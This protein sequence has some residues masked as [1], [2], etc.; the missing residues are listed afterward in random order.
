MPMDAQAQAHANSQ[1]AN[2]MLALMEAVGEG[3]P[4]DSWM[5]AQNL[6]LVGRMF[7]DHTVLRAA[8]ADLTRYHDYM[9]ALGR[10]ARWRG[11]IYP[12]L[13][14]QLQGRP[15]ILRL[16]PTSRSQLRP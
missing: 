3:R 16:A 8:F 4:V 2:E 7:D 9:T 15:Q 10:N 6:S 1:L 11:E 12:A 5:P 14:K 13:V